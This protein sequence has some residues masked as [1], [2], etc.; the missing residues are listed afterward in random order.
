MSRATETEA[1]EPGTMASR[2]PAW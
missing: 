1:G 2:S